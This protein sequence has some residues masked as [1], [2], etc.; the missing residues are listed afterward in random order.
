M[1]LI[2]LVPRLTTDAA[3]TLWL[4]IETECDSPGQPGVRLNASGV[5]HLG[6]AGLQG[7]LIARARLHREGGRLEIE[8][9]S[10]E[11]L[12]GL[13]H[14]GAPDLMTADLIGGAA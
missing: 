8:A 5:R 3:Q 2:Q 10:D 6:A 14:M 9:P 13:D 4:E 12:A 1:R 7:L 11:F